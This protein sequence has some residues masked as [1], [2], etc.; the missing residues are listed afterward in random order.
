MSY[1]LFT[2]NAPNIYINHTIQIIAIVTF[3]IITESATLPIRIGQS[4]E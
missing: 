2:K 4:T 1:S 3:K